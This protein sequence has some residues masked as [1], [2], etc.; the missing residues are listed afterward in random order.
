MISVY[1]YKVIAHRMFY[2]G[3]LIKLHE[4]LIVSYFRYVYS[5]KGHSINDRQCIIKYTYTVKVNCSLVNTDC[6]NDTDVS[7]FLF[8]LVVLFCRIFVWPD[9]QV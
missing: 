1:L 4:L 8:L 2:F 9:V 7:F 3:I 5:S 6:I